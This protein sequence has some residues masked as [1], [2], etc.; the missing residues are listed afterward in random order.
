V[1]TSAETPPVTA[2]GRSH[3]PEEL[4]TG[5]L[6]LRVG[7]VALAVG[8][9]TAAAAVLEQAVGVQ[10]A[11]PVY[12]VAVVVA[13]GLLGTW[14]AVAT[15]GI[16][17]LVYDFLFTVPR[18]TLEVSDPAEWLSLLLFLI[19]AVVIGRLAALLRDR[20]EEADRRVREGVALV[21]MSRDVAMATT[22]EEAAAA[23]ALRLQADAEMADVWVDAAA[24]PGPAVAWT[25]PRPP[26]SPGVPWTLVRAEQD[27]TSEWIRLH[28]AAD[29][30][31]DD[32]GATVH[33]RVAIGEAEPPVGWIHATRAPD[34]PR[35]GR[36]ARRLFVLAADQLAIARRRDDLRAEL[37]AAEVAR[38]SDALR[39]AI[40]DS[41][42]HD[43][44][45]PVASI[46]ALAG[47]L[48]DAAFDLDAATVR[49][50]AE[51]IDAEGERLGDLVNGLLDM[52]RIQ[53]GSIR[54][55][56]RPYDVAELIETA[57]RHH[58]PDRA[59]RTVEVV[60]PDDLPPV[61]AD[62]VLVD[63]ALGNVVDNAASHTPTNATVRIVARAEG[64]MVVL[65]VDDAGPGVPAE[66]LPHLFERFY[67]V[68][69]GQEGARRGMGLGLAI[70]R[71][72]VEAMGG[73]ITA[74]TSDLGGLAVR[75]ALPTAVVE[76]DA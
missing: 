69:T 35:P 32:A 45:T 64:R 29:A 47:G 71:G 24:S 6:A 26:D 40:L 53:S 67:R 1:S 16:A 7:I 70:A 55:D 44:R 22:F 61:L 63:V 52:G 48:A 37:T 50:T 60:V 4:T 34:A 57:L 66:A 56:L 12:L 46:R 54:P 65:A 10:D 28:G 73:V 75:I 76:G 42:S 68:R 33:Y 3:A 21:A 5:E 31:A 2:H 30:V 23:I 62:A 15:S 41:V 72:F 27:G 36:G 14:A 58:P 25:G 38:E 20:A 43:L 59:A 9:A 19:V 39:G 8:L 17:F 18:F 13:A 74:Q 11:S 51:Q 49:S